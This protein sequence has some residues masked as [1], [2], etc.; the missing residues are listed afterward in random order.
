M[1]CMRERANNS[2]R[3][4]RPGALPNGVDD[5]R[6]NSRPLVHQP[7]VARRRQFQFVSERAASSQEQFMALGA[8]ARQQL[9]EKRERRRLHD[10]RA[11]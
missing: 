4:T 9:D 5:M 7:R 11:V 2:C 8:D 6:S 10:E 1:R 3:R